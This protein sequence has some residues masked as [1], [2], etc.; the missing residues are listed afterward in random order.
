MTLSC[1]YKPV[2]AFLRLSNA[3]GLWI[4]LWRTQG[5][6]FQ[7]SPNDATLCTFLS[8]SSPC[9]SLLRQQRA[10]AANVGLE[11]ESGFQ[12]NRGPL[13]LPSSHC[14]FFFCN[15]LT[16]DWR[17]SATNCLSQC[18]QLLMRSFDRF[19]VDLVKCCTIFGWKPGD[20]HTKMS[21]VYPFVLN[22]LMDSWTKKS[23]KH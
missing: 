17:M 16:P 20:H 10:I 2:D 9:L 22:S 23:R 21:S 11:M 13:K 15:R 3:A 19:P 1:L 6:V 12:H 18:V 5:G 8:A 14:A 7:D 4:A